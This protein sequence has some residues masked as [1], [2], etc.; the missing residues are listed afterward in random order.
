MRGTFFVNI[1][2][3]R[4]FALDSASFLL[5]VKGG[6]EELFLSEWSKNGRL[7]SL[8]EVIMVSVWQSLK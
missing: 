1:L 3:C 4:I 6:I 8:D 7:G 2:I 5:E